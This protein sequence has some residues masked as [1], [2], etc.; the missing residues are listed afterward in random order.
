VNR[1]CFET[2]AR[3]GSRG[4]TTKSQLETHTAP[5]CIDFS[6]IRQPLARREKTLAGKVLQRQPSYQ[7]A[8]VLG[9]KG[10]SVIAEGNLG[11]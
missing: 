1:L 4:G 11:G 9:H 2:L 5:S 3:P 10:G 8:S 7:P 6:R